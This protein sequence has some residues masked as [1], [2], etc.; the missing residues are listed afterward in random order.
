MRDP[1]QK[2]SDEPEQARAPGS[3]AARPARAIIMARRQ[4]F[5]T[6]AL[7]GV[8]LTSCEDRR[9]P[10]HVCLEIA[11]TPDPPPPAPTSSS[12]AEPELSIPTAAPTPC[13][14]LAVPPPT[15]A[16]TGAPSAAPPP[17][18]PQPRICLDFN[19]LDEEVIEGP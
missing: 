14:E 18:P 15:P 11:P 7:A 13:L 4:F 17:A 2:P 16:P 6:S 12:S 9:L 19:A 5:I 1:D 3:D 8:A 10:P